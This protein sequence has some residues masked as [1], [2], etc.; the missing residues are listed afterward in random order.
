MGK[1]ILQ[2]VVIIAPGSTSGTCLDLRERS[3]TQQMLVLLGNQIQGKFG[4]QWFISSQVPA[5]P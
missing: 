4:A 2:E 3:S 5:P 1:K